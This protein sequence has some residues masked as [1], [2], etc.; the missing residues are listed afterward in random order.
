MARVWGSKASWRDGPCSAREIEET[1]SVECRHAS[2][3]V[4]AVSVAAVFSEVRGSPVIIRGWSFW[5]KKEIGG[6]RFGTTWTD[7]YLTPRR[8]GCECTN[9]PARCIIG[10]PG[11]P[12]HISD[13][14]TPLAIWCG[15][16]RT[17]ARRAFWPTEQCLAG[18]YD[19]FGTTA[20]RFSEV[21]DRRP[22]A[23]QRSNRPVDGDRRPLGAGPAPAHRLVSGARAP[24]QAS[25]E[26]TPRAGMNLPPH[27]SPH[28]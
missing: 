1:A 11:S 9:T 28:C 15:L 6:V 10:A 26:D 12:E 27:P 16:T 8:G 3:P 7:R 25:P 19:R 4:D 24:P 21:A 2:R 20:P 13:R 18:R 22:P 23:P 17:N 5:C 14:S